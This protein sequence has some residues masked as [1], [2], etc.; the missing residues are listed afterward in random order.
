MVKRMR[1]IIFVLFISFNLSAAD[2]EN[3]QPRT[4]YCENLMFEFTL[5][6][7]SDPSDKELQNLCTCLEGEVSKEAQ[8]I[9]FKVKKGKAKFTE[10]DIV[11]LQSE[12]GGGLQSCG[13]MKM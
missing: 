11:L 10:K 12:F 2:K 13:A 3:W 9:N 1:K 5:D 8:D 6:Y 7:Y 4:F